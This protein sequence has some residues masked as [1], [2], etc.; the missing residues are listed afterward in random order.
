MKFRVGVL[1]H[2]AIVNMRFDLLEETVRS[3][4]V[5][6]GDKP[7]VFDNGSDDGTGDVLS[8][9]NEHV[10]GVYM[11]CASGHE[12]CGG[13]RHTPGLGT[14]LLVGELQCWSPRHQAIVVL[15]DDDMSWGAD[16]GSRLTEV[17]KHAPEDVVIVSS[18]LEPDYPWSTPREVVQ[19]GSERILVRDSCP[20]AAWTFRARDW[21]LFGPVQE[22]FGQDVA[23]CEALRAKGYRVAQIDLAEHLGRGRSTW[24]NE[25][26]DFARPLD[27]EKWGI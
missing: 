5:A 24:G 16:A 25:A 12:A 7:R 27:R 10:A 4:H 11:P 14:N 1:T 21:G 17:W 19:C 8:A 23:A 22:E 9:R 2:N 18:L 15:S 3:L 26:V 13:R 6:F 20:A